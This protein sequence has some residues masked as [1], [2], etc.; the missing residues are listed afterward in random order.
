MKL[1][2]GFV[3]S[4][5]AVAVFFLSPAEDA[6]AQCRLKVVNKSFNCSFKSDSDFVSRG[7]ACLQF[8]RTT[9]EPQKFDLVEF[10]G[11]SISGVVVYSC[12]C[13]PA[14]N[15]VDPKFNQ[16]ARSFTCAGLDFFEFDGDMVEAPQAFQGT[17]A[18]NGRRIVGH[19]VDILA[20]SYLLSCGI[21]PSCGAGAGGAVRAGKPGASE[22]I[23]EKVDAL[24]R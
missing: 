23:R 6:Q 7:R 3:S 9:G 16:S 17:I 22:A 5:L 15:I 24:E 10:G 4:L 2:G 1:N 13:D 20:D 11:S 21:V 12:T 18:P 8:E 14:G 19:E